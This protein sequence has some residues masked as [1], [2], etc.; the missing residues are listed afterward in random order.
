MMDRVKVMTKFN[1]SNSQIVVSVGKHSMWF[2]NIH[3]VDISDRKDNRTR[4]LLNFTVDQDR[5]VAAPDAFL[6]TMSRTQMIT[7]I[8]TRVCVDQIADLLGWDETKI[9]LVNQGQMQ[10]LIFI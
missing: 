3:A 9:I 5:D 2:K 6:F 8:Q 7:A 4:W 1:P 10:L